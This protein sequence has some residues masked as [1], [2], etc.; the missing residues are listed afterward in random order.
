MKKLPAKKIENPV[1]QLKDNQKIEKS[2]N[3]Q[4]FG[5]PIA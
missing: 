4:L 5:Q 1:L 3:F 2:S